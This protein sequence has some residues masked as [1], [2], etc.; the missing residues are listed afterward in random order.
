MSFSN[1]VVINS[2]SGFSV[3]FSVIIVLRSARCMS[4]LSVGVVEQVDH[5]TLIHC[6][7]IP[8]VLSL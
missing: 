8:Q 7:Y 5:G 1:S 6:M 4:L 2:L 3:P